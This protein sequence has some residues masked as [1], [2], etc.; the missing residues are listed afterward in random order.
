MP[1]YGRN[2]YSWKVSGLHKVDAQK[3]GE[4]FE[5]LTDADK[6]LSPEKVVEASRS[7]D[8]VLH[9]EFEWNDEAAAEKYRVEQARSLIRNLMVTVVEPESNTPV[10]T[11]A[12]VHIAQ[13]YHPIQTVIKSQT[14]METLLATALRDAET[15]R[16]KYATLKFLESVLNDMEQAEN[17]IRE[18]IKHT[19]E[20]R[21]ANKQSVTST[22][23]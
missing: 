12:F 20:R 3:A 9:G 18:E 17:R 8:A 16:N 23:I 13:D 4:E 21:I 14:E 1:L 2:V 7:E 22:H 10:E 5:K 15:F 11:R 6:N 19:E